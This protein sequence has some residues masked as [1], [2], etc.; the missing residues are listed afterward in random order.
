MTQV[1]LIDI[2]EDRAG[3][4]LDNFLLALARSVPKTRFYRAI[5][6][7]EVR[8]NGKRAKPD[9]RLET[10]DQ[11]RVPPLEVKQQDEA[12]TVAPHLLDKIEQAILYEDEDLLVLNKWAGIPVHGGT[13]VS[14]GVIDAIRQARPALAQAELVHR[15]DKGTSGCLII[16]KKRSALRH[17]HEQIRE[18]QMEKRYLC[19]AKGYFGHPK[20]RVNAPLKK[21]ILQSGERMVKV[22]PEGKESMTDFIL[23]QQFNGCCELEAILHTGRTHQ[24]RVHLQHLGHP[25]AGD[26]K[27]GDKHFNKEMSEAG[28]KR[29]FLHAHS[30]RFNLPKT[31]KS[32]TVA[33][34]LTQDLQACLNHLA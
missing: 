22:D 12:T 14:F 10:G 21:N 15:L 13:D 28:L 30:L 33:A 1:Q 34:P 25:L 17:L 4:R 8:V 23:R 3:Q 2:S 9:L 18:G 31:G 26:E 16:A 32:I 20:R 5:R 29:L 7:G 27:Y 11:V 6:K 19:L 24:I